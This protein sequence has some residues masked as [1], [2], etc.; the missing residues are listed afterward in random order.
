MRGGGRLQFALGPP[1][2]RLARTVV[3]PGIAV[4]DALP[5]A[6]SVYAGNEAL[7]APGLPGAYLLDDGR[8]WPVSCAAELTDDQT[9]LTIV[10][11]A[12]YASHQ[13]GLP[14]YCLQ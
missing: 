1:A 11:A 6:A 8:L 10:T 12:Q 9:S 5:Y 2:T 3:D 13:Q 4:F 7:G 14:L